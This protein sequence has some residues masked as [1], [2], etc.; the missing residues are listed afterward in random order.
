LEY[1]G[2]GAFIDDIVYDSPADE[3]GIKGGDII[4]SF[5]GKEV[6]DVSD[7]RRL[8]RRTKPKTKVQIELIRDGKKKKVT[9]EIGRRKD[10]N[11]IRIYTDYL[12]RVKVHNKSCYNYNPRGAYLG[13]HMEDMPDQLLE[14][15]KAKFGVLVTQVV[16]DSPAEKAGIKAGDVITEFRHR[17]VE[18]VSDLQ[19]LIAK[20]DPEDEVEIKVIRDG[21]E[22]TMKVKLGKQKDFYKYDDNESGYIDA[23]K[24]YKHSVKGL[25]KERI[26]MSLE[27][28]ALKQEFKRMKKQIA[29][30]TIDLRDLEDIP[31]IIEDALDEVDVYM[32]VESHAAN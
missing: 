5:D 13:I 12:P 18:D 14:Y 24:K 21:S 23:K 7:L 3:A 1:K 28:D 27:N 16:E 31:E 25:N 29:G 2:D 22:K 32:D 11:N 8:I 6:L 17:E 10:G 9:A 15:F 19:F 4:I 20:R 26:R 30:A